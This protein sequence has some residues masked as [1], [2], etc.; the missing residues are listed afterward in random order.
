MPTATV[1]I[2][3][4]LLSAST[5]EFEAGMKKAS[6]A[7]TNFLK[8]LK[9]S[10]NEAEKVSAAMTNAFKGA[11]AG[12]AGL[13]K[14]IAGLVGLD[15]IQQANTYAKA[16]ESIGGASKLTA[17]E[18]AKVNA[19]VTQAIEKY[20]V[21]GRE[22]PEAL[23]ALQKATTPLV[24]SNKQWVD[25]LNK[26]GDQA[27]QAGMTLTKAL[28]VPIVAVAGASVKAA[29]DFESSFAGIRKTVDGVVD[30][31]GNLTA[32]G[33]QMQQAMR[34]LAKEI[35]V[36]V[37][38]L[39]KLGETA[40]E[41]GIPQQK[42][43]EFTK[44]MAEL[45]VTTNLTADEAA[46]SIGRIQNIF[47]AA[48][49]DTERFASTLV[50]LGNAG[51]STE[52]EITEMSLRI[53]GAG[54]AVGL[55]QG[56]VLAFASSLASVGINAEAGGSAISRVF[57]KINDAVAKGNKDMAEFARVAGMGAAEFKKAFQEDAAGATQKFIEG[58]GRLKAS[59]ENINA[60][61]EGLIGKN[62]ILKDTLLRLSGA[63]DLVA[64]NLAL[65]DKAWRENTA[66]TKEA[67]QRFK[68][69]ESQL[70][71]LWNRI[72]DVGIT[73]GNALLPAIHAGISA[74]TTLLPIIDTLA[75]GFAAMPGAMQLVVLGFFGILAAA[76][77]VLIIFGQMAKG[78]AD[79]IA[80]FGKQ[81][82]ASKLLATDTLAA[83]AA[84][85]KLTTGLGLLGK[86]AAVAGAAFVGW[87]I[88]R[89]IADLFD[90]DKKIADSMTGLNN[91]A[92]ARDLTAQGK[93]GE[94]QA[95][96]TAKLI[97]LDKEHTAALYRLDF[98][99]AA[100]LVKQMEALK[101][102]QT[103]LAI[104][105]SINLAIKRG[106]DAHITYTE[107]VKFNAEWIKKAADDQLWWNTQTTAGAAAATAAG[108][109]T[110][111]LAALNAQY[112]EDLK[113]IGP[114]IKEILPLHDQYK[115]SAKEIATELGVAETTIDRYLT[116]VKASGKATKEAAKEMKEST[117]FL[118]KFNKGVQDLTD[119]MT[120]LDSQQ[121]KLW[122]KTIAKAL[123]DL[124][125]ES[126]K[127]VDKWKKIGEEAGEKFRIGMKKSNEK[128][129]DDLETTEKKWI[130]LTKDSLDKRLT[131][132]RLDFD[133]RRRELDQNSSLY[134]VHLAQLNDEEA[135]A[136]AAGT[137]TWEKEMAA[138]KD[139]ILGTLGGALQ[140]LGDMIPGITGDII[141]GIGAVTSAA[142]GM[143]QSVQGALTFTMTAAFTAINIL[144]KLQDTLTQTEFMAA[145]SQRGGAGQVRL[146]AMAAGFNANAVLMARTATEFR[147]AL[148]NFDAA[149][150]AS[151]ERLSKYGLTW[152]DMGND[153]RK[154]NIDQMTRDLV[155]D[156]QAL[157]RA[158]VDS[159]KLIKGM[160]GAFNQLIIDAVATGQKIP[161]ALQ[162][163]LN[164]LIRSGQLSEEAARALLGM[165]GEAVVSFK[166]VEEAAKRY[167]IQIDKLGPKITQLKITDIANQIIKDWKLLQA[168]GADTNATLDGMADE[169]QELVTEALRAG[170]KIP[171]GMRPIIEAL[172]AAGRLVDENGNK[173]TD[174]GSLE[175]EKP[176]VE[177]IDDLIAKLDEL[178]DHFSAVGT[179][180]EEGF[181]RAGAAGA[182][183]TGG[184]AVPRGAPP[185][186]PGTPPPAGGGA[187]PRAPTPAPGTPPD[188][189]GAP[190]GAPPPGS[191]GTPLPR[192]TD[193]RRRY[194][195]GGLVRKILPFP[196]PLG[197]D[198]VPVMAQAGEGWLNEPA[199]RILGQTGLDQL[200]RASLHPPEA[201]T[202]QE[203]DDV[204]LMKTG[205]ENQNVYVE[206]TVEG[207]IIDTRRRAVEIGTAIG[208]QL[209]TDA[210]LRDVWRT[211]IKG[212]TGSGL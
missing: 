49:Q 3:K 76:G 186:A 177:A 31:S 44:V 142:V 116:A 134:Q 205:T 97:A 195:H 130:Q 202:Q 173:L 68:T 175:F 184:V 146:D 72:Q 59:G 203:R 172:I 52:K 200:N 82:V 123:E 64:K 125:D 193:P 28:T 111:K 156:F 21:I 78:A 29:I 14:A 210:Q 98:V 169:V 95:E 57:L 181:G 178:I 131:L 1:G 32:A 79:L 80:M 12:T 4:I 143:T 171:E 101:N 179:A 144:K 2:L 70:K 81:G 9:A 157:S 151:Q 30:S 58:L 183:A 86:A 84:S 88:G 83:E 115:Q 71:L 159:T 60:T 208:K 46:N 135:Q 166:D 212:I 53:A 11:E 91:L 197:E 74:F 112:A 149:V 20:Q 47:G 190:T 23:K 189:T 106:A 204:P 87:Q 48:G 199:M 162:P 185:A 35:P 188:Q 100:L 152:R 66:L 67:E 108:A 118:F 102:D 99:T 132:I 128:F 211:P 43:V 34:D 73:I 42:V 160:S 174:M 139:T 15:V 104:Q 148:A 207:E 187:A 122:E 18:Q 129:L 54:H 150:S 119:T 191:T 145:I 180:A 51:A 103:R 114:R 7:S 164:T 147:I 50:A 126:R 6:S 24:D 94:A 5:A 165:S 16:V 153:I 10:G 45:G 124:N 36:S 110:S 89:L 107:A 17:A 127:I 90:L 192:P 133:K 168:A 163:M 138:R 77:P 158:G 56:Q 63:G 41:L 22:A 65:Q 161:A 141:S 26:V 96:V 38:E 176:L 8:E 137:A 206:V 140:Q 93:T 13:G 62:I 33:K 198:T 69:T 19:S 201:I 75:K 105:D 85:S 55:T 155:K 25:N 121:E 40:G 61:M 117:D 170:V 120:K 167:G 39:N 109:S 182:A 209:R 37:N 136:L 92:R 113:K 196:T 154:A 27:T 194:A